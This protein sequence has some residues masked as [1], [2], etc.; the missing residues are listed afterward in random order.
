[1]DILRFFLYINQ[2]RIGKDKVCIIPLYVYIHPFNC[3]SILEPIVKVQDYLIESF[4]TL[5]QCFASKS[6][7]FLYSQILDKLIRRTVTL[8]LKFLRF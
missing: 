8:L 2:I 1:M 7:C 6:N 5:T 3:L 4:Q